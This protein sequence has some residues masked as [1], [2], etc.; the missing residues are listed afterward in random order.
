VPGKGIIVERPGGWT[1]IRIHHRTHDPLY[2]S[3]QDEGRFNAPHGE[4]G[5]CY[6]GDTLASALLETLIRSSKY[7]VVPR[8]ELATRFATTFELSRP[9][10][11]LQLH[12]AGLVTLRLSAAFPHAVP[13][14]ECQ[15]LSAEICN[16][17]DVDGIEYRCCWDDSLFCVA[18]FDRAPDSLRVIGDPIPLDD[19]HHIRP[20]LKAYDIGVI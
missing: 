13:Y 17:Q 11:L 19:L 9:V 7:L 20:V 16:R 10:R 12:S 15:S 3:R 2:F 6:F 8:R 5:V 14:G 4:F 1:L 18:L